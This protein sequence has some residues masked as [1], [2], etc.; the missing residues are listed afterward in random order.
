MRLSITLL[1]VLVICG[2]LAEAIRADDEAAYRTQVLHDQFHCDPGTLHH[3]LENYFRAGSADSEWAPR[4]EIGL[5]DW[6]RTSADGSDV[7]V[8]C[9]GDLCAVDFLVSF[10]EFRTTYRPMVEEWEQAKHGGFL[11]DSFSF[12]RGDGSTR[13]FVFRDSFDPAGLP[14]RP[15]E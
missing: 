15:C 14:D 5:S 2:I 7:D 10:H 13:L 6:F 11:K 8:A 12:P 9:V 4:A 3:R 1:T